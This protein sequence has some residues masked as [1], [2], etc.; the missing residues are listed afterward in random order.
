MTI[1]CLHGNL[2]QPN[3][4]HPFENRWTYQ[5][6]AITLQYPNMRPQAGDD[7]ARWASR[8][9]ASVAQSVSQTGKA[10]RQWLLGY[11][12]GGRLALHA[13]LAQPNLWAGIVVAGAHP[14]I[15]DEKARQQQ[16]VRDSA[17]AERFSNEPLT[18][19]F[20]E[21]DTLPVFG[22]ISNP[23]AR[24]VNNFDREQIAD[25][26]TRF[27]KGRQL[28]LLPDLALLEQPPILY[29]SGEK[30]ARYTLLGKMLA[31]RCPVIQH[32]II[33]EAG[34]RV[35][36]ENPAAFVKI[37]QVFLDQTSYHTL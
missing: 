9:C 27:S 12:L 20:A 30:D 18:A 5:G 35:P 16:L 3:V 31:K 10:Q 26:F 14:G 2:Q 34:H 24:E 1:W 11:S 17:W 13:A 19:L 29:I 8:F 15:A 7:C 36:W 6:N 22:G 4:W 28:Y 25:T 23:T 33:P 37:I 21:W 32:H